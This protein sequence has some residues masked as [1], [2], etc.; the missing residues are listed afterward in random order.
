MSTSNPPKQFLIYIL[1]VI[2]AASI[3]TYFRI[4]PLRSLTKNDSSGKA[5][6]IVLSK[7]K[8]QVEN[9]VN[10]NYP[11]LP[12]AEKELLKRKLFKELLQ[13][14][15]TKVNE[16]IRKVSENIEK[17]SP[18]HRD[19]PYLLESDSFH[20]Y[21]LTEQLINTGQISDT[22][23]GSKYL[24]KL[25]LA[26]KGHL[27]PVTLHPLVGAYIY[28][29][30][31]LFNPDIDLM[32]AV[33]FTPLVLSVIALV[34]FVWICRLLNS[35]VLN[36]FIGSVFFMCSPIFVK[37]SAFGWYDNDPYNILFPMAILLAM[38]YA[39][40]PAS[41]PIK[42]N[43]LIIALSS[44][45]LAYA[46]FWQGWMLIFVIVMASG[47]LIL[48]VSKIM[49]KDPQSFKRQLHFFVGILCLSVFLI[50]LKFGL[51]GYIAV[52]QEGFKALENFMTPQLSPWPDLYI[53]VGELHKASLWQIIILTGGFVQFLFILSGLVISLFLGWKKKDTFSLFV[54]LT[55]G[56]FF[57]VTL[58]ISLGAQRFALLC[59]PPFSILFVLGLNKISDLTG[60]VCLKYLPVKNARLIRFVSQ[61]IFVFLIIIPIYTLQRSMPILL[62]KIY[63]DTWHSA[64]LSIRDETPENS[65]INTWWPPGHFIKSTAHRRVTFDGA[66]INYPQ[67]YWL[68]R[69]YLSQ[70]ERE[71]LGLL[72]ML[73][74]SAND[75]A[76]YL[77]TLGFSVASSV[78]ILRTITYLD[79][80]QARLLLSTKISPES[81]IDHL[82]KL[83]HSI[84]DPSYLFIY[85]ELIE[86]NIQLAFIGKWN[87][88]RI[89]EIN[90]DPSLLKEVPDRKSKEYV[91][92]LWNLAG[93]PFKYNLPFQEMTRREE[94]VL[95]DENIKVNLK[96]HDCLIDSPKFGR[97]IPESIFYRQNNKIVEQVFDKPTLTYSVVLYQEGEKYNVV[98]LDRYLANS[99]IMRLY[100]FGDTGYKYFKTFTEESDLDKRTDIRVFS[101]DWGQFQK[102]QTF[103]TS[104]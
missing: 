52:F 37:R 33:S 14:E 10:S 57:L 32:Y 51:A 62:N 97:G 103:H 59:V 4:Y 18:R 9:R 89:E 40:K 70:S 78:A 79:E 88:Q 35:T 12:S 39:L 38:F 76:E 102:D 7:L 60:N 73:N 46:L 95:F 28:R 43:L 91:Q 54:T 13:Q 63:N 58:Y 94:W 87:F 5:T 21:Q 29:T 22:I 82:L 19:T 85:S 77:K 26:P 15:G 44:L 72:R 101:V 99:L 64:L 8:A 24:N 30:L 67:A 55:L 66:T 61:G 41:S 69:V 104:Q 2:L 1:A 74:S 42:T 11:D 75:A 49:N 84:P 93:G 47:A 56:I 53:S 25:M 23:T 68:T 16:T 86:K 90:R 81:K 98:L 83:T 96:T 20:F 34:I 27:E 48:F 36:T 31:K 3:G 6:L 80:A 100:Y 45:M 17:L 92:F 65:I 50:S 71:A